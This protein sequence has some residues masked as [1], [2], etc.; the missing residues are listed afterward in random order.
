MLRRLAIFSL[1]AFLL[2]PPGVGEAGPRARRVRPSD[3]RW[4]NNFLVNGP[5][6]SRSAAIRIVR[7]LAANDN[8]AL[9]LL[10]VEPP[11]RFNTNEVE[12]GVIGRP[13]GGYFVQRGGEFNVSPRKRGYAVVHHSHPVQPRMNRDRT[14]EDL[15]AKGDVGGWVTPSS[16]YGD[17]DYMLW[18]KQAEHVVHLGYVHRGG[19]VIGNPREG[20]DLP[21]VDLVIT[22][23][24]QRERFGL[25]ANG[26][27]PRVSIYTV[28]A[29]YRAGGDSI[30]KGTYYIIVKPG[31]RIVTLDASIAEAARAEGKRV[32]Q[33]KARRTRAAGQ[34]KQRPRGRRPSGPRDPPI[35]VTRAED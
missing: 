26:A 7:R 21:T 34:R 35:R 15:L 29:D 6:K 24:V 5:L 11:R 22:R 27:V 30:W 4:K 1:F 23:P 14:I 19:G 20:E 2:V 32:V 3:I 17:L 13:G 18:R 8:S 31:E 33:R 16:V 10:G 25:R 28:D 12:W 9:R